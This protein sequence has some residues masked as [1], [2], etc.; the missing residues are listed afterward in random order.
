MRRSN[1]DIEWSSFYNIIPLRLSKVFRYCSTDVCLSKVPSPPAA[2]VPT[3]RLAYVKRNVDAN[4]AEWDQ[5]QLAEVTEA[6][7]RHTHAY[8]HT[9][10]ELTNIKSYRHKVDVFQWIMS[11]CEVRTQTAA[12]LPL[13]PHSAPP[14]KQTPTLPPKS[15][16]SYY[17]YHYL[18]I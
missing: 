2:G 15:Q 16:I 8:T 5:R 10:G 13:P 14:P 12:F 7:W 18:M 1:V 17:Y 4:G 11:W 6:R 9:I 3:H